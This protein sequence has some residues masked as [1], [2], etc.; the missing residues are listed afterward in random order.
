VTVARQARAS[1]VVLDG[2]RGVR[3]AN[4]DPQAARQ[5]LYEVGSTLSVTGTTTI[6][7]SEADPHD[8]AFF[9]KPP[10]LM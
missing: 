1:V 10:P 3:A 8:P 7:M 9:P 5:F 4:V 2:F 6:I